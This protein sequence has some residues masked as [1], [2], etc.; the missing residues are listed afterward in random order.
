MAKLTK[1]TVDAFVASATGT[2]RF[3]WDNGDGAI[4][5]FGIRM[6][7]SG[8]AA[9]LVQY[10]NAEGRTRRLALGRVGV[11]T[12]EA[13]RELAREKLGQVCKGSDPSSE[14]QAARSD[15]TVTELCDL[16][17]QDIRGKV[18]P[19][20]RAADRSRI[21]CHIKPRLGQRV[22]KG[23]TL[24]DMEKFHNEVAAGKTA[25]PERTS[26]RGAT[27]KGG[28]SAANRTLATLSIILSFAQRR[29][30]I[31]ENPATGVKRFKNKRR[32]RILTTDE[33]KAL[34]KAMLESETE[35]ARGIAIIKALL[36]T[37]CR[38]NEILSL[39]W[40]SLDSQAKCMRFED[41][42]TGPQIR[43]LGTTAIKH[44]TAQS[45]PQSPWVFPADRGEGH[46]I[47]VRKVFVRL[48]DKAG[49]KNAPLHTLRHTFASK[50]GELN[51][52][53]FTIAGMIG[54]KVPGITARYTHL[55]DAALVSAADRVSAHLEA[56]LV[57][58][59]APAAILPIAMAR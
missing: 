31:A 43:P 13:A 11:L 45:G 37:G 40:E 15:I 23:L 57:G 5:G 35:N 50:A 33:L 16:Y 32:K 9:Y 49:I 30:I 58:K 27:A 48:C 25:K 2:E 24:T 38:R 12:P 26:G 44:L 18:K 22:V 55:P 1:R 39:T 56:I 42:K 34:G 6:K 7:P 8:V 10:R 3:I 28:Q 46:F 47:G 17:L 41:T 51:Y 20:T 52:S 14:R 59:K 29:N 54:H 36:F 53:E 19:S 4:K 21:E